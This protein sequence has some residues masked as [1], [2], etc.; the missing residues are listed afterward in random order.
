M[1]SVSCGAFCEKESTGWVVPSDMDFRDRS[2]CLNDEASVLPALCFITPR[3]IRPFLERIDETSSHCIFADVNSFVR[4]VGIVPYP[5]VEHPP[6]HP[7]V[8]PDGD[9]VL[10]WQIPTAAQFK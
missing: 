1:P 10:D 9:P 3:N 8:C 7:L 4:H 5:V 6:C 2:P